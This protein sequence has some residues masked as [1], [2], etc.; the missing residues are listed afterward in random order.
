MAFLVIWR[1]GIP[2]GIKI[3]YHETVKACAMASIK[4]VI[5]DFAR[6]VSDRQKIALET[7]GF[8]W[9]TARCQAGLIQFQVGGEWSCRKVVVFRNERSSFRSLPVRCWSYVANRLIATGLE[10]KT[11]A[12]RSIS[13]CRRRRFLPARRRTMRCR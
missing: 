4:S 6:K 11:I 1:T 12:A 8:T 2:S 10:K 7:I 9:T 13:R 5:A 3:R